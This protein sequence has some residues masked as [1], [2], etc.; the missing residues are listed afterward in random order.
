LRAP[1][2]VH[3]RVAI[4][5]SDRTALVFSDFRR[6]GSWYVLRGKNPAEFFDLGPDALAPDFVPRTLA[7]SSRRS[8]KSALLDQSFVAG[9]GN[10][11]A[12]ESLFAARIHPERE[13]RSLSSR[14]RAALV[15]S[16]RRILA[17]SIR[18][19]GATLEDYRSTE[20]QAGDYEL[21]FSVFGREGKK[22]PHCN[23]DGTIL[24]IVIGGRST[25]ICPVRQR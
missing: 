5:L 10:I 8:I 19:G 15:R 12:S 24:R 18:R 20:G 23:C 21:Q 3:D 11:Y 1:G 6:F 25:F 13:I 22:C 16:I 4:E 9:I 7:S 14:E 2:E 17:A